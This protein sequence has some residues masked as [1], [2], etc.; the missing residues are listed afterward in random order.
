MFTGIIQEIG[1]VTKVDRKSNVLLWDNTKGDVFELTIECSIV[2]KG[3]YIGCSI[4]V[5]GVCLTVTS[6]DDH[7]FTTQC[8]TETLNRTN[9]GLLHDNDKVNLESAC[10]ISNGK[11]SGHYVQ[12]HVDCTASILEKWNDNNSLWIKVQP[13][14]EYM[15]YIVPKGFCAIDGTS[16]TVCDVNYVDNWFTFML[17]PHTQEHII[18]P[19]KEIGDQVN[20]ETDIFGKY[21][22]QYVSSLEQQMKSFENRMFSVIEKLEKRIEQLEQKQ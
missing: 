20:I 5:N 10:D 12:G 16:L 7:S 22:I 2:L 3:A 21:S 17:I 6:F 4:A 15:K 8:S 14:S 18:I 11:N 19:L 9:L 1:T 13:K